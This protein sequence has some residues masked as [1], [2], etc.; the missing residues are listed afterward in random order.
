[1]ESSG[2]FPQ[3]SL[4]KEGVLAPVRLG[5]HRDYLVLPCCGGFGHFL[6]LGRGRVNRSSKGVRNCR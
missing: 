3:E 2:A 1:M 5:L 4:T 6:F